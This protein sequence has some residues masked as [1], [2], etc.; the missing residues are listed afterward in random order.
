MRWKT[1]GEHTILSDAGYSVARYHVG[2]KP[3]FRA[4]LGAKF[5]G[6]TYDTGA[7]ARAVCDRHEAAQKKK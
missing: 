2:A 3:V 1:T 5:I 6:G 4:S 7:D